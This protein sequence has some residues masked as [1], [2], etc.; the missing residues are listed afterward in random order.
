MTDS[1]SPT[2]TS[3]FRGSYQAATVD[4][5]PCLAHLEIGQVL[6]QG[7]K[8]QDMDRGTQNPV[9]VTDQMM[10]S[11]SLQIPTMA[12]KN[13]LQFPLRVQHNP[14]S[15]HTLWC[16]KNTLISPIIHTCDATGIGQHRAAALPST[17]SH[18][19][20]EMQETCMG[21]DKHRG[22]TAQVRKGRILSSLF[23]HSSILP[24]QS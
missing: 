9:L 21:R 17:C 19:A 11:P 13:R 15:F 8:V 22:P 2:I 5:H 3:G 6:R 1:L 20:T 10:Q 16:T 12:K 4:S 23:P 14:W 18:P 24:G 7:I